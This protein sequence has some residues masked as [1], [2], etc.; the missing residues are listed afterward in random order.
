M[1]FKWGELLV[2]NSAI[3]TFLS[4]FLESPLLKDGGGRWVSLEVELK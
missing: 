4:S 1:A 3:D 2:G